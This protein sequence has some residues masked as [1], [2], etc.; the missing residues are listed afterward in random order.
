MKITEYLETRID[1][2]TDEK[3]LVLYWIEQQG[4]GELDLERTSWACY[5]Q[6]YRS[7]SQK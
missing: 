1:L 4:R 5:V 3:D 6:E 7:R 2:S